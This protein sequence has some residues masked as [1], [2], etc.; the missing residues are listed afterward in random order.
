MSMNELQRKVFTL[1]E[2]VDKCCTANGISYYLHAE[3]ALHVY[4]TGELHPQAPYAKLAIFA[5]S[6]DRFLEALAEMKQEDRSIEHW[7]N[8]EKYPDFS[9]RYSDKNSLCYDIATHKAYKCNGAYLII[10]IIRKEEDAQLSKMRLERGIRFNSGISYRNL[11]LKRLILKY[12][13][14]VLMCLRG[15]KNFLSKHFRRNVRSSAERSLLY[16][17]D[18][19]LLPYLFFEGRTNYI[20]L[21]GR[22]F[23]TFNHLESYFQHCFGQAWREKES[24]TLSPNLIVDATISWESYKKTLDK[25][26]W[27]DKK[28]FISA[29]IISLIRS[30][31][32]NGKV[33]M[34]QVVTSD[35]VNIIYLKELYLPKKAEIMKLYSEKD[36]NSLRE[37]LA[38]YIALIEKQGKALKFDA[39]LFE[40]AMRILKKEKGEIYTNRI[41]STARRYDLPTLVCRAEMWFKSNG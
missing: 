41:R 30:D 36:F 38:Y 3:T 15:R 27:T 24:F 40:I 34:Q 13:V 22:Q 39:D 14:K 7:G 10:T 21:L 33:R 16:R 28:Y 31:R 6:V 9:I 2:E 23:Q 12:G 5:S 25:Y 35:I 20:E 32:L 11:H 37:E 8:N 26:N 18:T 29:K 1:L 19:R 17:T 4:K